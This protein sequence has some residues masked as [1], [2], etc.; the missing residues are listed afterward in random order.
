M[1]DWIRTILI[2]ATTGVAAAGVNYLLTRRRE[3]RTRFVALLQPLTA[4]LALVR[5]ALYELETGDESGTFEP[6]SVIRD[7]AV[8][9]DH[10]R[11][12]GL[13]EDLAIPLAAA[14]QS[15][16]PREE[17]HGPDFRAQARKV[18]EALVAVAKYLRES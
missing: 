18:E 15:L 16:Y 4:T 11:A 14:G 8:K 3:R 2:S 7:A 10:A 5:R 6:V 13:P 1:P 9:L 12:M 17:E